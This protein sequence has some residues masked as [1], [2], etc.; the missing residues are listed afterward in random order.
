[1]KTTLSV[2]GYDDWEDPYLDRR[3]GAVAARYRTG[4]RPGRG[5]PDTHG[6]RRVPD[7]RG[8][9]EGRA[10]GQ[11]GHLL[12]RCRAGTGQDC[13]GL[14]RVVSENQAF[15]CSIP[16]SSSVRHLKAPPL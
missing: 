9:G 10:S 14:Q 15:I 1:T 5:L 2:G 7:L 12:D 4:T 6:N 8:R 13:R 16:M 11:I 3:R